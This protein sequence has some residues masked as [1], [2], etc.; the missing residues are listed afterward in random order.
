MPTNSN[1][2]GKH[3]REYFKKVDKVMKQ[4]GATDLSGKISQAEGRV[5]RIGSKPQKFVI[6][7]TPPKS[8]QANGRVTRKA[9]KK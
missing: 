2:N 7:V 4:K 6:K 3:L 5:H 1:N 9:P 8:N